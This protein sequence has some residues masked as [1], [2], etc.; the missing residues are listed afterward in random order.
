[1]HEIKW[2]LARLGFYA[3]I[4]FALFSVVGGYLTAPLMTYYFFGDWR[5]WRHASPGLRLFPHGWK[6]MALILRGQNNGFLLSVDLTSQPFTAPDRDVVKLASTWDPGTSCGPCMRC[7][8]IIN[9]PVLDKKTQLC[10][11]YNSFFW[12]YFNC[13]RYPSEQSEI[14]YYTCPKWVMKPAPRPAEE[15]LGSP[16]YPVPGTD[17]ALGTE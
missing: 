11:G 10:M 12:R 16:P 5:F 17:E 13:G 2:A 3:Y 6:M 7:C 4:T 1:M 8:E 14:D 15:P 9:C